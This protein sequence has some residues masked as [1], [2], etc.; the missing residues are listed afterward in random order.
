MIRY[1]ERFL[2]KVHLTQQLTEEPEEPEEEP[3]EEAKQ[4]DDS[5][6]SSDDSSDSDSDFDD[7]NGGTD[8]EGDQTDPEPEQEQE[9][10]SA[11][12]QIDTAPKKICLTDFK[13]PS[14]GVRRNGRAPSQKE[15]ETI[16]KAMIK[17]AGTKSR[18]D[19]ARLLVSDQNSAICSMHISRVIGL[20]KELSSPPP[21]WGA[22]EE[23]HYERALTLKPKNAEAIMEFMNRHCIVSSEQVHA[24]MELV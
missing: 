1:W 8:D 7:Y 21:I 23:K 24:R 11:P 13:P 15:K 6:D 5:D 19:I 10:P 16:R 14:R 17:Y 4:P 20:M 18:E 3:E 2:D 9:P 12:M 22:S